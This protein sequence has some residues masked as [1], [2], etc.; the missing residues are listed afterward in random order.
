[1]KMRN[2]TLA[3][4]FAL[5]LLFFSCN[6][7]KAPQA[8]FD[9]KIHDNGRVVF[10]NTTVGFT[11]GFEWEFGD[12]QTSKE[13]SP[14]HVYQKK[15]SYVVKLKAF[16]SV[17][18]SQYSETIEIDIDENNPLINM[19]FY[20]DADAILHAVNLYTYVLDSGGVYIEVIYGSAFAGFFDKNYYFLDVGPV[21]ING[22]LTIKATNNVYSYEPKDT[23]FYFDGEVN[24]TVSGG[25]GFPTIIESMKSGFPAISAITAN[26]SLDKSFSYSMSTQSQ[27]I[28]SDS[29]K[30][31]I[32]DK[33]GK[34]VAS[35]TLAG[36]ENSYSFT[37]DELKNVP[38]GQAK[39]RIIAIR[40]F[41]N[42]YQN[43]KVYFLN[44][45]V[46]EKNITVQ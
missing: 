41:T 15:G 26:A 25:N 28:L 11:D 45:A 16:N 43:K 7:E 32:V 39:A 33:L 2:I 9:Y 1:M 31:E 23:S 42:T 17:G 38:T 24:W 13:T 34:I 6:K 3:L 37:P 8:K 44:Q 10:T 27:I 21:N 22:K 40:L 4:S 30:F 46:V 35:K 12:S 5:S 19:P 20:T 29:N 36:T 18:S 14:T